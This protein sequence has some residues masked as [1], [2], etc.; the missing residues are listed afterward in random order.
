M[1]GTTRGAAAARARKA[2]LA[3]ANVAELAQEARSVRVVASGV[4]TLE[5]HTA[6]PLRRDFVE[7]L[8]ALKRA[9]QEAAPGAPLPTWACAGHVFEVRRTGSKRGSL[10]LDVPDVMSLSLNPHA[11]SGLPSAMVEVRARHL[12]QDLDAA[13]EEAEHVLS[14]LTHGEHPEMQVSRVDVTVDWQG[15]APSS[16]LLDA[17]VTRA[18]RDST[19]RQNRRHT[20]WSWGGGGAV[21]C[22]VYDKTREIHGTEKAQ[23]FPAVW[24]RTADFNEAA[25]VWRC[26]YQVRREAIRELAPLGIGP[27]TFRAWETCRPHIGSIFST[28]SDAWCALRLPRTADTRRELDPRWQAIRQGA[29]WEGCVTPVE[30]E[31][32]Q[33]EAEFSRTLDQL[34]AYVCRGIAERW[35]VRGRDEEAHVTYDKLFTEIAR[36]LERKGE[37]IDG[38][39]HELYEPLRVQAEAMHHR[40][41]RRRARAAA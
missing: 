17:F 9:A 25:P 5:L 30:L 18:R 2:E 13:G 32:L 4:D 35:A 6:Q 20:G 19:Y 36:H 22:R 41:A 11:P 26:E 14:V 7:R 33:A 21:L 23:W 8:E 37:T 3:A 27:G 15:W 1:A 24:R 38:R 28:L 39:A 34:S 40:R 10:L 16:S 12:W 29:R 31:R